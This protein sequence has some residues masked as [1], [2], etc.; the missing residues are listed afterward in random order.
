[1]RERDRPTFN[2][3]H[4][5]CKLKKV[6][7]LFIILAFGLSS[8]IVLPAQVMEQKAP[9]QIKKETG[10]NPAFGKYK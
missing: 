10:Y 4:E 3:K 8:C 7:L 2:L 5:R 9:G 6:I 1:M